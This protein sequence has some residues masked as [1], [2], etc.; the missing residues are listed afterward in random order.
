MAEKKKLNKPL[1]IVLII[2]FFPAAIV[3][4]I[5]AGKKKTEGAVD[6]S[7][8]SGFITKLVCAGIWA[9]NGIYRLI[10]LSMYVDATSG[11]MF[12]LPGVVIAGVL[13]ALAFLS[14]EKKQYNIIYLTFLGVVL[15][16]CIVTGMYGYLLYGMLGSIVGIFGGIRGIKYSDWVASGRPVQDAVSQEEK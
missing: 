14:K 8:K 11:L 3:Y 9:V 10:Q 6:L 1:L 13:F 7:K 15:V 5:V 2:V 4:A 12:G 16:V